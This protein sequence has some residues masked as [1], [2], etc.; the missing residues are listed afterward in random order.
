MPT[1]S[2]FAQNSCNDATRATL[3]L[4]LRRDGTAREVAWQ[5]FYDLYQ[6]IIS[7]FARRLGASAQETDELAQ[8]V[9]QAFFRVVPEF[10]YDPDKG[11]FR[12]YL[13]TCVCNKLRDLRRR[14]IA[15]GAAGGSAPDVDELAVETVWNDVWETEKLH[16]ALN[17][18]RRR[19]STNPERARTFRAFEMCTLLERSTEEVAAELG[20]SLESVRAAKS[21]ISKAVRQEF[22]KI[23]DPLMNDGDE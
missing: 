19:Y 21:R 3:L 10:N 5:E 16:R 11:S 18:V 12:G 6:P 4:R 9:M 13:K 1:M 15:A 22:D 20:V 14:R 17:R 23:G 8:D 7:G 2:S